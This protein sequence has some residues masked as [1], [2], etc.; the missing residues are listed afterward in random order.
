MDK[1]NI[2][3]YIKNYKWRSVFF[4]H[5][6][7]VLI[8][9]LLLFLPYS[10]L[11]YYYYNSTITKEATTFTEQQLLKTANTIDSII[12]EVDTYNTLISYNSYTRTFL[13]RP[14]IPLEG[15]ISSELLRPVQ[16]LITNFMIVSQHRKAIYIYSLN[17]NFVLSNTT[18]GDISKFSDN[19]WYKHYKETGIGDFRIINNENGVHDLLISKEIIDTNGKKIGLFVVVTDTA[20]IDSLVNQNELQITETDGK[21]LYST[22]HNYTETYNIDKKELSKEKCTSVIKNGRIYSSILSD[23]LLIYTS[24][25]P[26]QYFRKNLYGMGVLILCGSIAALILVFLFA[27]YATAKMYTS[28]VEIISLIQTNTGEYISSDEYNETLFISNNI[29]KIIDN[30]NK[31]EEELS[32]RLQLLKKAQSIALQ[33]QINPHFLFNTLQMV[34][35]F[36][37]KSLKG[38]NEA[39][40]IIS[41]LSELLRISLDTKQNIIPVSTEIEHAKKYIEIQSIKYKNRF[42]VSWNISQDTLELKTIKLVLQPILENAVTHGIAHLKNKMGHLNISVWAD[43]KYLNMV[44][45][46]N[47]VGMESETLVAITERL[48]SESIIENTHIGLANVHQ[49]IQLIY[50]KDYGVTIKSE[51][52][53]GTFA[54]IKLPRILKGD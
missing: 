2:L 16:E 3:T 49:R 29:L 48:N 38:D 5:F 30:N 53:S 19:L 52:N 46:D 9:I 33:T 28:I 31:I 45:E 41:L 40:K 8:A 54:Y 44:V 36:I 37:I 34:N 27:F 42:D 32:K 51:Q 1:K 18:G 12:S 7:N 25:L 4:N 21:M 24:I 47:G 23:N 39:T 50:G 6:R 15:K 35:L 14:S 17:N 13:L 26:M 43:E 22:N 11:I 10:V 20:K